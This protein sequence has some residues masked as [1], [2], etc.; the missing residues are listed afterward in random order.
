MSGAA[1]FHLRMAV[2]RFSLEC[3]GSALPHP[4]CLGPG[5]KSLGNHRSPEHSMIPRF[6][7]NTQLTPTSADNELQV[8]SGG[9]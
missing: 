3:V 4:G 7:P 8:L 2:K 5:N 9:A 1:G 6:P